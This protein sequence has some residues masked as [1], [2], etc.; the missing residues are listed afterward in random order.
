M[1]SDYIGV[2]R[3]EADG[4]NISHKKEFTRVQSIIKVSKHNTSF[5]V[6]NSSTKCVESEYTFYKKKQNRSKIE[7]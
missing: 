3:A 1:D 4:E 2:S 7:T 6:I 5:V